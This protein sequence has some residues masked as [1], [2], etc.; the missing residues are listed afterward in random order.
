MSDAPRPGPAGWRTG[1]PPV[2]AQSSRGVRR[3]LVLCLFAAVTAAAVGILLYIRPAEPPVM[4]SFPVSE[5]KL[6]TWPPNPFAEEDGDALQAAFPALPRR[7]NNYD[8]QDEARLHAK[9]RE[10]KAV[11]SDRPVI[12]HFTALGAVE[13]GTV[14]ILPG[15]PGNDPSNWL[16]LD[17]VLDAL[18]DCRAKHRLLLLDIAKPT[19]NLFRG[20]LTDSVARHLDEHLTKRAAEGRLNYF[21]LTSCSADEFSL[22]MPEEQQAAFAFYLAEGIRGAA[23]GFG[24]TGQV[25]Q[26]V[27]VGE[28]AAYVTRR[29]SRWARD[30]RGTAQTPK[31][32]GNAKDFD[33]TDKP[34]PI[35]PPADLPDRKAA[36]AYP[37]WLTDDWKKRDG[38]LVGSP[39]RPAV[40]R[41]SPAAV[42][43][44]QAALPEAER[45]WQAAARPDRVG[46][47]KDYLNS[48][49]EN[50]AAA[51]YRDAWTTPLRSM[52]TWNVRPNPPADWPTLLEDL[53]AARLRAEADPKEEAKVKEARAKF[54][55]KTKGPPETRR[56]AAV[57]LWRRLADDANPKEVV[58]SE[59]L[60]LLDENEQAARTPEAAAAHRLAAWQRDRPGG[61]P[62]SPRAVRQ[63]LQTEEA[64]NAALAAGPDGFLAARDLFDS[65]RK[66]REQGQTELFNTDVEK[67]NLKTQE[68]AA[69][70]L[71]RA[72]STF[73]AAEGRMRT[74]QRARRAVEDAALVLP[75]L[76]GRIADE[77]TT[78]A[79]SWR[80][81]AKA[82]AALNDRLERPAGGEFLEDDWNSAIDRLA[83]LLEALQKPYRPEAVKRRAAELA[84]G[85]APEYHALH[86][87]L[88]GPLLSA[89]DRKLVYDTARAIAD[90][91]HEQTREADIADDDTRRPPGPGRTPE[92]PLKDEFERPRR[93]RRAEF[94]I[95]LLRVAGLEKAKD[96]DAARKKAAD[97]PAAWEKLGDEL[98]K[99]WSDGL[100][101][102]AK[103][104]RAKGDW[105]AADRRERFLTPEQVPANRPAA[106]EVRQADRQAYAEWVGGD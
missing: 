25:N 83:P 49:V 10:L 20:P 99:A 52:R 31:L 40:F 88:R 72:E 50:A 14:Y 19:A 73:V 76:A 48:A 4:L 86:A 68:D 95:A 42:N 97:T 6:L 16:K 37:P 69:A 63:V 18:E 62:W 64:A 57:L 81:A 44:L 46:R 47:I 98:R 93:D 36:R 103:A 53:L 59:L 30:C 9:L 71:R 78:D 3:F 58:F 80:E 87:L 54:L 11:Q 29:V 32:Y 5:Y 56:A 89:A 39:D 61:T 8:Y 94:S 12:V 28:L 21:V 91:L 35:D 55:E 17:D 15:K 79:D 65:A 22:P 33:L 106:A 7:E 2:P 70:V 1:E 92:P 77:G 41:T 67:R 96:L 90:K 23:D 27:Q 13:N 60:A 45:A 51:T 24:A 74:V 66:L 104:R 82:A 26:R 38:W 85:R 75:A 105:P 34:K 102:D 43:V 100:K 84:T 101:D